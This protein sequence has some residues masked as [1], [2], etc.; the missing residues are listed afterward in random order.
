MMDEITL[1]KP[2]EQELESLGVKNWPIWT[3]E[4]SRFDWQYDQAEV[5]Y[6]LE[7]K[8]TVITSDGNVDFGAGDLVSFPAG[9]KCTWQVDEAVRKH[10]R[11]G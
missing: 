1:S 2:T 3:C 4:P 8:V 6:L 5:C 11:L 10:Y 7:G 9:L